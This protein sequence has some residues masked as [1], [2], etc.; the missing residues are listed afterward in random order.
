MKIFK[1]L[2]VLLVVVL[3]SCSS[4]KVYDDYDKS[5]DFTQYKF[6]AFQKS[7]ID[8]VEIS[9]LDK[10]RILR[11]IDTQMALKG[12]AKSATP[13]LLINI[14]TKEREQVEV[15]EFNAGW[16]YGWGWGWNPHMWGGNTSVSSYVEGTLYIDLIDAR[17]RELV[18][19][20]QGV[21]VLSQERE[22]KEKQINEFVEKIL[23]QY[24][25]VKK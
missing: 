4:V 10:K 24:P 13:D 25:P 1:F 11:A 23:A 17:K 6:Y 14:F 2:P 12:F 20:G 22:K 9:D 5:V 19:Q 16:G 8:K 21:G 7:G 18:W 3:T 15:N